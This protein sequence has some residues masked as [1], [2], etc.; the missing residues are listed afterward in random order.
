MPHL[1]EGKGRGKRKEGRERRGTV[2][3]WEEAGHG[4]WRGDRNTKGKSRVRQLRREKRKRDKHIKTREKHETRKKRKGKKRLGQEREDT[5]NAIRVN[6]KS[7]Q[8]K[9]VEGSDERKVKEKNK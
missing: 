1:P 3:G 8:Q 5:D 4:R 6:N 9:G 2:I 7:T